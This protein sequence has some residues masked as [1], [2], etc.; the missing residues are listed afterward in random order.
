VLLDGAPRTVVGVMPRGFSYP[1]GADFWMPLRADGPQSGPWSFNVH[2]RLAP[3]VALETAQAGLRDL[4]PELEALLPDLHRGMTPIAIPVRETLL[5]GHDR[6]LGGLLAAVGFLA[7]LVTANL[8]ALFLVRL[9]ERGREFAVRAALGAG[10]AGLVTPF[11]VESAV[12]VLTGA[13]LGLAAAAVVS[14]LLAVLVPDA[15]AD[16]GSAPPLGSGVV[17]FTVALAAIVAL[18]VSLPAAWGA[19]RKDPAS[20]LHGSARTVGRPRRWRGQR[21]LAASQVGLALALAIGAA[22]LLG[23]VGRRFAAGPG[24]D[25]PESVVTFALALNS[26]AMAT[27][28]ARRLAVDR[29][30]ERLAALPGVASAGASTIFPSPNG[31]QV[32]QIEIEGRPADEAVRWLANSR[33]VTPGFL[34]TLGLAPLRGRLLTAA[35][36]AEAPPAVV[37]SASLARR[38]FGDADPLGRRMRDWR[39]PSGRWLEVVG[40]VPDVREFYDVEDSWYL[41]YAQHAE[42]RVAAG[43]VFALRAGQPGPGFAALRGAVA[44]VHADLAVADLTTAAGHLADALGPA[45]TAARFATFFAAAGLVLA[46]LGIYGTVARSV[47]GRRREIGLRLALGARRDRIVGLFLRQGVTTAIAGA[48]CGVLVGALGGRWLLAR[49][50]AGPDATL[51]L[52]VAAL[53]ALVVMAAVVGATLHP[54]LRASRLDP[55]RVLREE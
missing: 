36:G 30:T 26:P 15:L 28:E 42:S 6:M 29:L 48:A 19:A 5:D 50:G 13:T 37:I 55:G 54:S 41:P 12:V 45:R 40:V 39:D 31:N 4:A 20:G 23:D 9:E 53:A 47:A 2:A 17:A 49:A 3:G 25:D 27:P 38:A 46:A 11:L 1:Y 21:V 14:P 24:Y 51:D 16:L 52:T 35:D 8:A 44:E 32:A 10:G 43:V 22:A 18:L 34:P 7:L 33:V